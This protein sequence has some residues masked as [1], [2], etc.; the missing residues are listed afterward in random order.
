MEEKRRKGPVE[1]TTFKKSGPWGVWELGGG[2]TR[3]GS[4]PINQ[5][6]YPQKEVKIMVQQKTLKSTTERGNLNQIG[7]GEGGKYDA[8][9]AGLGQEPGKNAVLR[10]NKKLRQDHKLPQREPASRNHTKGQG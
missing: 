7:E 10:G 4:K 1:K 9:R 3:S 2:G 5:G 8:R 6:F